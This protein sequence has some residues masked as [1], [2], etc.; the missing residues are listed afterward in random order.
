MISGF[1]PLDVMHSILMLIR[2]L[3]EGRC[4][5]ENQYTRAVNHNGNVKSQQLMAETLEIRRHI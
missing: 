1:E 5:V 3:N 4:A 2:Q